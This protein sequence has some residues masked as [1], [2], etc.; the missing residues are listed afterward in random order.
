M[1]PLDLRT[2]LIVNMQN[3]CFM[4]NK[5]DENSFKDSCGDVLLG[6]KIQWDRI[7]PNI[8]ERIKMQS[9]NLFFYH[10]KYFTLFGS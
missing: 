1:T 7:L 5:M 6:I 2:N 3:F 10:R 8:L 9:R 4:Y